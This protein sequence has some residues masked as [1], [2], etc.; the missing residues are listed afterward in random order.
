MEGSEG[1]RIDE[2]DSRNAAERFHNVSQRES[3]V[4][5]PEIW[6]NAVQEEIKEIRETSRDDKPVNRRI[7]NLS[8]RKKKKGE[9]ADGVE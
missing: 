7:W 3:P 8:G 9:K 4:F 6:G 5:L 2:S 1:L